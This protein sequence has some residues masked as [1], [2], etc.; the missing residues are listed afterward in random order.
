MSAVWCSL[1]AGFFH[2]YLFNPDNGGCMFLWNIRLSLNYKGWQLIRPYSST[3][4]LQSDSL[5]VTSLTALLRNLH[6]WLKYCFRKKHQVNLKPFYTICAP[7]ITRDETGVHTNKHHLLSSRELQ[8][9]EAI[10]CKNFLIIQRCVGYS[11]ELF[12]S[13]GLSV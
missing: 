11:H 1:F 8:S 13:S 3:N 7:L 6:L 5:V 4:R 12:C 2:G 9:K 10:Y